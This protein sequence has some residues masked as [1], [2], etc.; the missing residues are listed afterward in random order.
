MDSNYQEIL[1]AARYC[2][3]VYDAMTIIGNTTDTEVL[4]A[5]NPEKL[6]I[7]FSGSES[8]VDWKQNLDFKLVNYYKQAKVHSGFLECFES[9]KHQVFEFLTDKPICCVGH[10]L[11]GAIATIMATYIKS[12]YPQRLVTSITFGSPKPG[13]QEFAE[14]YQ[15]LNIPTYRIVNSIDIV[16]SLPRWWQGQYKHVC[17][18]KYIG[19]NINKSQQL[20]NADKIKSHYI[21][22]Y[23]ATLNELVQINKI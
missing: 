23:V 11:G 1:E 9:V 6:I 12:V 10:S 15:S 20:L 14:L 13:N 16:P 4:V 2:S 19:T 18:P 3:K 21:S 17:E 8:V 22:S 5:D 7:S